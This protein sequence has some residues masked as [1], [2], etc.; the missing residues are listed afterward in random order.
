MLILES[1]DYSF[2]DVAMYTN[3]IVVCCNV[4]GNATTVKLGKFDLSLYKLFLNVLNYER[5]DEIECIISYYN[6]NSSL[7]L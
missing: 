5:Y 2:R 1:I 3:F 4:F 6:G 7:W